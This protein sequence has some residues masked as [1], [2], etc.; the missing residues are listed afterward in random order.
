MSNSQKIDR[1]VYLLR[2]I[3]GNYIPQEEYP[4]YKALDIAI[5]LLRSGQAIRENCYKVSLS[6]NNDKLKAATEEYDNNLNL[7]NNIY[8]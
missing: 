1:I 5:S 6:W 8:E 7:T 2:H 3:Q 4:R